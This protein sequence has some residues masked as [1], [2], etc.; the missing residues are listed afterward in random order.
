MGLFGKNKSKN[1]GDNSVMQDKVAKGIAGFLLS[2]QTRFA[3]IMNAWTNQLSTGAKRFWLVIFCLVFGGFSIYAFIG[4]FRNNE[5]SSRSIKPA[6]VSF[7]KYYHQQELH[8]VPTVSKNDMLRIDRFK[9]YMDSLQ[10]SKNGKGIY[11]SIIKARPG[12]MDSIKVI[13]QL[14]YS[15][16]K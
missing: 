7:P 5:N 16:S 2:V 6:Q 9:K 15:Q 3:S 1:K 11:D 13:E 14:Y 10:R 4:A 8:K 12:L